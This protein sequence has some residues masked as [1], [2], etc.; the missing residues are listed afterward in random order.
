MVWCFSIMVTTR[1]MDLEKRKDEGEIVL[2]NEIK[3]ISDCLDNL[4]TEQKPLPFE[5]TTSCFGKM[6]C[7][8]TSSHVKEPELFMKKPLDSWSIQKIWEQ[9]GTQQKN[10]KFVSCFPSSGV[11]RSPLRRSSE[12]DQEHVGELKRFRY[13]TL[14]ADT[15]FRFVALTDAALKTFVGTC[16][17]HHSQTCRDRSRSVNVQRFLNSHIFYR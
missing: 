6:F 1:R 3:K 4:W 9:R 14:E 16:S 2:C 11:S 10:R 17:C 7:L 15:L 12:A 13:S 8:L 5:S